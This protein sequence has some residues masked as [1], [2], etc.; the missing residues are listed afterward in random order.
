MSRAAPYFSLG[1]PTRNRGDFAEQAVQFILDQKFQ[2]FELVIADSDESGDTLKRL[3]RFQD[4]RIQYHNTCGKT[5]P[6]NF[7][8]CA[9]QAR[10]EYFLLL[11]DRVRLRPH[12]LE[13]LY[14][15]SESKRYPSIRYHYDTFDGRQS[16]PKIWRPEYCGEN[17]LITADELLSQ[18]V[19]GS[20][21]AEVHRFMPLAQFS[22]IHRGLM[23]KIRGTQGR[24]MFAPI[25]PDMW[26]CFAQLSC[27]ED[28]FLNLGQSLSVL[29]IQDGSAAARFLL[30]NESGSRFLREISK[31]GELDMEHVPIKALLTNNMIYNDYF[32]AQKVYGG[33]LLNHPLLPAT[34]FAGIHTNFGDSMKV[35]A[36]TR[37]E[38]R[39]WKQ[40]LAQ[41]PADVQKEV[42][43][44]L[45]SGKSY[46][47]METSRLIKKV[48]YAL[49]INRLESSLKSLRRAKKKKS[50]PSFKTVAEY[51]AY[52]PGQNAAE[53]ATHK[54]VMVL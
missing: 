26:C 16:P 47:Q 10:G 27:C 54:K 36:N 4:P 7:Q 23:E 35:G 18:Y 3:Q 46:A 15:Q 40:A 12:A 43:R 14:Q 48:R 19:N 29:V 20:A 30:K 52:D 38:Y 8:F 9:E 42:A 33:R 49:G 34:Y 11:T 28:Q 13:V 21:G 32:R 41:Q 45:S 5:G 44:R 1:L 24:P 25:V 39:E 22:A 17:R 50:R 37:A 31:N 2:D 51:V 6:E 53:P